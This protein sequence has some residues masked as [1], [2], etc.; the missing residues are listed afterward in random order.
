MKFSFAAVTTVFVLGSCLLG[1]S[2]AKKARKR[3]SSNV[4]T[5]DNNEVLEG[6][7]FVAGEGMLSEADEAELA[8]GARYL[9]AKENKNALPQVRGGARKLSTK[10]APDLVRSAV[11]SAVGFLVLF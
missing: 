6:M 4:A 9:N 7:T 5:E 11:S 1:S 3:Q 2:D 10:A 8:K